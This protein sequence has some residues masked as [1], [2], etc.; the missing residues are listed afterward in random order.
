[1]EKTS[2]RKHAQTLRKEATKEEN[3]LWY[4]F[5]RDYP[6]QFRRQKTFGRYIVDFFCEKAA[7]VVEL[8]GSQH[9]DGDGPE[10]DQSRTKWL[11]QVCHIKVLRF[12][13]LDIKRRFG[14]VCTEIDE[15]VKEALP[16]SVSAAPS[17][18]PPG[19]GKRSTMKQV[20]IYTDGACS[21]NPGPG[22]G[23]PSS[24]MGSFARSSPAARP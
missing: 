20:T 5:L 21:G 7:L 3:H 4:D 18:L 19:E 1:M 23:G 11:E 8:D 16:S 2:L 12:T 14:G 6:I 10:H 13:N 17:H 9:Y 22:A 24:S 15:R